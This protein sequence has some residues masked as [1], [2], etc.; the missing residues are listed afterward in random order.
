MAKHAQHSQPKKSWF[1]R[2]SQRKQNA[3]GCVPT[4]ENREESP[5][6]KAQESASAEE[7]PADNPTAAEA[8]VGQEQTSPSVAAENAQAP[9]AERPRL[10]GIPEINAPGSEDRR[11]ESAPGKRVP[12]EGARLP[13]STPAQD[14][15]AAMYDPRIRSRQQHPADPRANAPQQQSTQDG[16]APRTAGS[17]PNRLNIPPIDPAGQDAP[18]TGAPDARQYPSA[19]TQPPVGAPAYWNPAATGSVPVYG[20]PAYTQPAPYGAPAYVQYAPN[21]TPMYVHYA[22]GAAPMYIPY[23]PSGN[24]AQGVYPGPYAPPAVKQEKN[25][26]LGCLIPAIAV[27]V[28][29]F[30]VVA[31][32]AITRPSFAQPLIEGAFGIQETAPIAASEGPVVFEDISDVAMTEE[33][34]QAEQQE[35]VHT[36]RLLAQCQGVDIY[37]PISQDELTGVIMHQ[38]SYEWG[39]VMTTQAPQADMA[40]YEA[41]GKPLR[42]NNEQTDGLWVDADIAHLY[43]DT[44]DT[45]MD[46]AADVGGEAGTTVYAPVT[47]QVIAVESYDLYDETP[48]IRIHIRPDANPDLDVVLL[49]QTDPTVQAGDRVEAGITPVS[50]V[51]DIAAELTDLQLAYYTQTAGNHSHVQ[52][53]DLT[54]PDYIAKYNLQV[55]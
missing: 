53:N 47:G 8:T 12:Q 38:A 44:D 32:F 19:G 54:N 55:D 42:V 10:S 21:G 43:R 29:L 51:R 40:E 14:A 39:Q 16:P 18:R 3:A 37:S 24:P 45:A 34:A 46:T 2:S 9:A 15:G 49:H 7:T 48:D 5:S 25:R 30:A 23:P 36:R 31:L 4:P 26:R 22:P 35:Q 13:E 41:S 1:G 28:T 17:R 27:P 6:G 11:K 33:A 20:A 50:S 52:V